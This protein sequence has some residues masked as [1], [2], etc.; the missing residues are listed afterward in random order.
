MIDMIPVA[1][2]LDAS[3]R[4]LKAWHKGVPFKGY[5]LCELATAY[6]AATLLPRDDM[7]GRSVV[8]MDPVA[9]RGVFL[10]FGHWF[11]EEQDAAAEV[12]RVRV[13]RAKVEENLM[14]FGVNHDDAR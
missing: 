7:P 12:E 2:D 1:Q 5:C 10:E 3:A 8:A 11:V 4:C 14:K 9:I 6:R 13:V